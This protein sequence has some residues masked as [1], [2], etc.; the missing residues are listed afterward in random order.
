MD[1]LQTSIGYAFS[2]IEL[3]TRSLTHRSYAVENN[4][5]DNERLEFLGDGF[6]NMVVGSH[7]FSLY[8]DFDEGQLSNARAQIVNGKNLC[9]M[10]KNHNIGKFIRLG[11]GEEQTGGRGKSSNLANAFE[12]II[13]AIFLD[14]S[15][16]SGRNVVVAIFEE[17]MRR[18]MIIENCKGRL[19]QIC[20]KN[21]QCKPIYVVAKE[22][23]PEHDKIFLVKVKIND[24]ITGS[25]S[26][27][28]KREAE[29]LAAK[30]ALEKEMGNDAQNKIEG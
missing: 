27:K 20:E 5:K 9:Q 4:T 25:G 16:E 14:S 6:L 11:K 21:Y 10:A 1:C 2:D 29:Q 12:A 3:L 26:G 24:K 30:E 8:P 19:Q 18:G 22:K 23:G 15:Y 13:G 17:E 28:S 7:L